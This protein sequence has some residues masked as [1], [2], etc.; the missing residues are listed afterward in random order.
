[1][2]VI[3]LTGNI[4]TGKSTVLKMLARLGAATIDADKVAHQVIEPGGPAYTATIKAFGSQ[5]L[6]DDGTIDRARLGQIVFNDPAALKHLERLTHPAV[7]EIIARRLA[8]MD[9]PVGVIEAIKLVEAGLHTGVDALWIVTAPHEQQVRRLMETR[10][11]SREEAETRINA[12]PPIEPK[13]ALADV[14]I[15]NTGTIE[16]LWEH[17]QSNWNQIPEEAR[18]AS[19]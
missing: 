13:L 3:G 2:Y 10:G 16:E 17:V 12:Q 8:E 4:A 5:I 15:E 6:R 19:K 14:I 7:G 18:R 9:A 1:M 11:L